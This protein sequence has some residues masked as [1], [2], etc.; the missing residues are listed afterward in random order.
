MFIDRSE[1]PCAL[2]RSSATARMLGS[3]LRIHLRAWMFVCCVGSGLCDERIARSDEDQ[4]VC[5]SVC[6]QKLGGPVP[7]GYVV[8]Q[9]EKRVQ[10]VVKGEVR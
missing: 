5:K 2:R 3:R 9:R 10:W 1:W 7:S 4:R 6:G 8:T